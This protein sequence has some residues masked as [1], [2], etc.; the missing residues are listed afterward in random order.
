MAARSG[1]MLNLRR[2]CRFCRNWI[3]G[4]SS[5]SLN[6]KQREHEKQHQHV[7]RICSEEFLEGSHRSAYDKLECHMVEVH[8]I[9]LNEHVNYLEEMQVQRA[10]ALLNEPCFENT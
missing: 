10:H 7:C 5:A 1:A 8:H 2:K 9:D 3:Y 6:E 4:T